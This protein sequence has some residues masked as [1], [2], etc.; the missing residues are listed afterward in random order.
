MHDGL[1]ARSPRAL[2]RR[3]ALVDKLALPLAQTM[4]YSSMI[5]ISVHE[6]HINWDAILHLV[7]EGENHVITQD[8][9]PIAKFE[10]IE[11][12]PWGALSSPIAEGLRAYLP[13]GEDVTPLYPN[14]FPPLPGD[15]V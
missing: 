7:E 15:L 2:H 3:E 5:S 4:Q 11:S 13:P 6:L 12:T 8:G 10:R 14:R 1:A 9:L